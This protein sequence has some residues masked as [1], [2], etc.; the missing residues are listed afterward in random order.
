MAATSENVSS[1]KDAIYL[2]E[3]VYFENFA[4]LPFGPAAQPSPDEVNPTVL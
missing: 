3:E 2:A 4:I 1:G